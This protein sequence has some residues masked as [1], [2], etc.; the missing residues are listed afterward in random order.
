VLLEVASAPDVSGLQFESR[1]PKDKLNDEMLRAVKAGAEEAMQVGVIAAYAMT[2]VKITV[3]DVTVDPERSDA[4]SFKIASSMAAREAFRIAS[5]ILLE[6]TMSVEVLVP[7]DFLSNI[8]KDLN[9]RRARVNNVGLR[10]HLQEVDAVAPLSGMFGY[11]T[12]LRSISQGRATYTMRFAS[13]EQVPD[14]VLKRIL[15]GEH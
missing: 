9:S 8:I 4:M 1:L 2:G 6:P 14:A 13:Y 12:D 7:D 11:T 10:G 5:P 15:G 3:L